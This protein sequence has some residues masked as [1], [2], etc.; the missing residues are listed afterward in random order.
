[1]NQKFENEEL[2]IRKRGNTWTRCSEKGGKLS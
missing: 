2:K 1:M